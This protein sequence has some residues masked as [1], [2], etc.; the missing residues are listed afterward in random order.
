MA[1]D[2]QLFLWLNGLVGKSPVLDWPVRLLVN[3]YFVPVVSSLVLVGLWF[4]GPNDEARMRNQKAL[5]NGAIGIGFANAL[6]KITNAYYYRPRP[7]IDHQVNLSL[8]YPPHDSSFPANAIAVAFGAAMGVWLY[9]RRVGTGLLVLAALYGLA[10]VIGGV[11][12]PV[13]V[14]AGAA[15][16]IAGGLLARPVLF[17]TGPIIGLVLKIGR[18]LYLA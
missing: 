17:I 7:F 11:H 4:L 5:I 14:L 8:F 10:R 9:N 16:G 6:V 15:W 13:D 12:Y 3:D 2:V 18:R 1:W